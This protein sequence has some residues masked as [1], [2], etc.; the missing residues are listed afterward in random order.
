MGK[1]FRPSFAFSKENVLSPIAADFIGGIIWG[2]S[3]EPRRCSNPPG[4]EIQSIRGHIC[5]LTVTNIILEARALLLGQFLAH[6]DRYNTLNE[7]SSL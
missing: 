6:S 3:R 5:H 7:F 4:D 1:P 2:T